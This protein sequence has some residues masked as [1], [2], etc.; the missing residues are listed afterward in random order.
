MGVVT[1]GIEVV[2][3]EGRSRAGGTVGVGT[4]G[5]EVVGVEGRSRV[6][7]AMGGE[8]RTVS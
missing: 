5:F 3:V 6:G 7:G 8:L 2:G 4:D 1:D